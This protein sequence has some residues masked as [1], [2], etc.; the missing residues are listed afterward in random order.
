MYNLGNQLET[1][2][3][4]RIEFINYGE[5]FSKS[6]LHFQQNTRNSYKNESKFLFI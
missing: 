1:N 4:R 3:L 2:S 5:K 6:I